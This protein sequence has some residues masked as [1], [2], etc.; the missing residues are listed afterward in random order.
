GA[1]V[2]VPATKPAALFFFSVGCGECV[3]GATS[4]AQAAERVGD[5]AVFVLVDMDPGESAQTV[6]GFQDSTGTRALPAVVDTGATLTKRYSVASLST[7][8][9]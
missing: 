3:G 9:V 7:L 8:V 2:S 5:K 1:S 6:T 4:L